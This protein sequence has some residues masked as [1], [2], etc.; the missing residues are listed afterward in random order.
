M[1]EKISIIIPEYSKKN[2]LINV[3]LVFKAK[4]SKY[5]NNSC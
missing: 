3:I 1:N 4:L 5:G 2:I